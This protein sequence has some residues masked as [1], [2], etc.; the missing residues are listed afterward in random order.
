LKISEEINDTLGLWYANWWLGMNLSWNCEFEKGLEFFEKSLE[1]GLSAKSLIPV[2]MTKAGIVVFNYA[3]CGKNNLAY[4]ISK[5]AMQ[6]AEESGDTYI[7]GIA[8]ASNGV[9]CYNKGLFDEAETSTLQ[10]AS[11]CEKASQAGWGAAAYGWLGHLYSDMAEY[12]KARC[13]YEKGI[14]ALE[15]TRIYPSWIH[16]WKLSVARSKVLDND[17]DINLD[18]IFGHLEKINLKTARGWATRHV[19][20][21]LLNMDDQHLSEGEG[22]VTKAIETDKTNGAMWSLAGD[23]ALYADLL[24]RK[25]DSSNARGNLAKAIDAFKECGADGW[26]KK[27]EEALAALT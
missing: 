22:W 8:S 16:M 5:E 25:G 18:E 13:Y 15:R 10:A 23:Y 6:L 14:S 21:I 26:V 7:K 1:L 12:E 9:A 20:E 3:Y 17:K 27:C 2:V 24:T 4:E 19:G 11:F